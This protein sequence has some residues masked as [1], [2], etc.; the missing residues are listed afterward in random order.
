MGRRAARMDL[1]GGDFEIVDRPSLRES[2]SRRAR[3]FSVLPEKVYCPTDFLS[4]CGQ[5]QRCRQS[6][7]AVELTDAID[8]DIVG[9]QRD[10]SMA[11]VSS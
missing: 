3:F 11:S 1:G 5:R 9:M 7:V 6:A 4:V 2:T 10:R 8:G